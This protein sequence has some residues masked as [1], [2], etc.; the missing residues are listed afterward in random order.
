MGDGRLATD[1]F[2]LEDWVTVEIG[3]RLGATPHP[4]GSITEFD[5]SKTPFD[6]KLYLTQKRHITTRKLHYI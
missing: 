3:S 5:Y 6:S 2:D 1:D 4:G